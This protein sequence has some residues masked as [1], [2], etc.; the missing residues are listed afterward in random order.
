MKENGSSLFVS[1][2]AQAM[3]HFLPS[4][5]EFMFGEHVRDMN[6]LT[7]AILN[8]ANERATRRGFRQFARAEKL[9]IEMKALEEEL[10]GH[11]A[12]G[13]TDKNR[14]TVVDLVAQLIKLS[15]QH[16]M[17]KEIFVLD[18]EKDNLLDKQNQWRRIID[19]LGEDGLS[20]LPRLLECSLDLLG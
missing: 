7:M 6:P 11:Q 1:S 10:E 17:E 5:A 9:E 14:G 4:I 2:S 13:I 19:H 16:A 18:E 20:F 3:L 15:G 8:A 12:D